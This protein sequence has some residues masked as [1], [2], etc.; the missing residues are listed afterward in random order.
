MTMAVRLAAEAGAPCSL[1]TRRGVRWRPPCS[2]PVLLT[3]SS[4]ASSSTYRP[5][6]SRRYSST[7]T[8]NFED[9]SK[10][11]VPLS[12]SDVLGAYKR[13]RAEG[14][15]PLDEL[16]DRLRQL[17]DLGPSRHDRRL[18][19]LVQDILVQREDLSLSALVDVSKAV[20]ALR[21]HNELAELSSLVA[22]SASFLSSD[23]IMSFAKTLT[24]T[25]RHA[26]FMIAASIRGDVFRILGEHMRESMFDASPVELSEALLAAAS[27]FCGARKGG[28]PDP[29]VVAPWHVDVFARNA[30][31]LVSSLDKFPTD[32][33]GARA[34]VKC[35]RAYKLLLLD[36]PPV[37][38]ELEEVQRSA[39]EQLPRRLA[40]ELRE[41][42][43]QVLPLRDVVRC[44]HAQ[45]VLHRHG[46]RLGPSG[47][48]FCQEAFRELQER[49]TELGLQ[50][51]V[52]S[53]ESLAILVRSG[54]RKLVTAELLSVLYAESQRH[55]MS[56]STRE[57]LAMASAARWLAPIQDPGV[58]LDLLA[59]E[60]L[61]EVRQL[62][63]AQIA[64]AT[65]AFA[66]LRFEGAGLF[67]GLSEAFV[68]SIQSFSPS[69]VATTLHSLAQ[70]ERLD[71]EVCKTAAPKIVMDLIGFK[72]RD[73][74]L[75]LWAFARISHRS[76]P[77]YTAVQ[78]D[79]RQQG[80]GGISRFSPAAVSMIL[81]GLSRIG[82]GLDPEVLASL[83][84]YVAS[85][86]RDF[87]PTALIVTCVAFARLNFAQQLVLVELYR[88][89]YGLLPRLND[90]QLAFC[91]FLF[92][93]SGV[94]DTSILTRFAY[95][96]RQR[97]HRLRGQDLANVTLACA[98]TMT[99]TS[100][101][102]TYTLKEVLKERIM[103]QLPEA[104][105]QAAPADGDMVRSPVGMAATPLLGLYLAAPSLLLLTR[106]E[107]LRLAVALRP[108]F[109]PLAEN[110]HASELTRALLATAKAELLHKPLL[111]PLFWAIRRARE[112]LTAA[113]VVSC[114]WSVHTLKF[115]KKKFRR[116]LGERLLHFVKKREIS[117]RALSDILPALSAYGF[118][119][120]LPGSLR[121]SIWR[122]S[123]DELRRGASPPPKP[124]M[125]MNRASFKPPTA[126]EVQRKADERDKAWKLAGIEKGYFRRRFRPGSDG[127]HLVAVTEHLEP[128]P[129]NP[130]D[131]ERREREEERAAMRQSL[132]ESG[133]IGPDGYRGTTAIEEFVEMVKRM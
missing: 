41:R 54:H 76:A 127:K 7:S 94:R 59:A 104:S 70:A 91:F 9:S 64:A 108:H 109:Q 73:L 29:A 126:E 22:E 15:T 115:C 130:E 81:W 26:P 48:A 77:F 28:A 21:L 86:C 50:D 25:Q 98:R 96:C 84:H 110:G 85:N 23:V 111:R 69:Q 61:R 116:T 124:N 13:R 79:L 53:L 6:R 62:T 33:E 99:P 100:L 47:I 78:E 30:S 66:A 14:H 58:V 107:S 133:Q 52:F 97:L 89:V 129:G 36:G 75:S 24:I 82:G 57:A 1:G 125:S 27:F 90:A 74:A 55:V 120:R 51:I 122:L 45:V 44:L 128:A 118:W 39:V 37:D 20:Q 3:A 114:I 112:K 16:V 38:P 2:Q 117:A 56:L 105:A 43:L 42:G 123:S 65:S 83:T 63:P 19:L 103:S 92:S 17:Q 5:C 132:E 40:E 18:Q 113:E 119:E 101:S 106:E 67:A 10:T 80:V 49:P 93:T 95:E 72:S 60:L 46:I 8:C 68:S 71:H 87:P 131:R 102:E 88:C 34:L 12:V 35:V 31:L 11:G 4:P 121:R 32:Q